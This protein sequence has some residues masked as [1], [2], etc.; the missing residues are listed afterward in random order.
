MNL[1]LSFFRLKN[2][3]QLSPFISLTSQKSLDC[4]KS[5]ISRFF[6]TFLQ[7]SNQ[8][9]FISF[10]EVSFSHFLN[11]AIKHTSHDL[12]NKEFTTKQIEKSKT[13]FEKCSFKNV[14]SI[15]QGG[16]IDTHFDLTLLE[17]RFSNTKSMNGGAVFCLGSMAIINSVFDRCN[18]YQ[19]GGAVCQ[20]FKELTTFEL[21]SSKFVSNAAQLS[22]AI[23]KKS[24]EKCIVHSDNFT[25]NKAAGCVGTGELVGYKLLVIYCFLC[26]NSALSH[27]GGFLFRRTEGGKITKTI[28]LKN[29]HNSQYR[30][31][32]AAICFIEPVSQNTVNSCLFIKCNNAMSYVISPG[33]IGSISIV[34]CNFTN[35]M[36]EAIFFSTHTYVAS[37]YFKKKMSD[38][39]M[40]PFDIEDDG[41]LCEPES[42][43]GHA[44]LA[45]LIALMVTLVC[46]I[47]QKKF[48]PIFFKSQSKKL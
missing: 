9:K 1:S 25:K 23:Y 31:A 10:N 17:C 39:I 21:N 34:N 43:E 42:K 30:E 11:T 46:S 24:T 7:T 27:N 6:S 29:S 26:K 48:F 14:E 33:S 13:K 35:P 19:T 44:F 16:C 47:I 3:F 36:N 22:G 20:E 15:G 18:A 40:T 32:A 12:S 45:F 38:K 5:Q 2:N 37:C 41:V 28:F 4:R 8:N